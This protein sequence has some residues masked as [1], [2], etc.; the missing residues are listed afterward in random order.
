MEN[1][2]VNGIIYSILEEQ[3]LE[4]KL[5]EQGFYVSMLFL[6]RPKGAKKFQGM[7]N[8]NGNVSIDLSTGTR[9]F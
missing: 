6:R 9:R 1:V 5:A 4:G 8:V 7:R 3:K 2:T